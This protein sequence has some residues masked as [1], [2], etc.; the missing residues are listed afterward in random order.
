[1]F[2][3]YGDFKRQ[4]PDRDPQE[5]QDWIDSLDSIVQRD[6]GSD[7]AQFI[8]YRLLKRAR[9]LHIGLPPLTQTRYINTI[10]PEQEPD[11][12][13]DEEM[14]LRIRRMVRWNAAAMVLRANN[15]YPGIGGHLA[16]YASA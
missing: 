8:L 2:D 14:E 13:G 4:L 16:T 15:N 10:S 12:P 7:R 11:F 9:Q 5:T 1:M 3:Q 6:G